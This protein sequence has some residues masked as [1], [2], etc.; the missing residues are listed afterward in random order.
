VPLH[1]VS[2]IP[3]H[4]QQRVAAC[5]TGTTNLDTV[6]F[7]TVYLPDT[8]DSMGS[9]RLVHTI[10]RVIDAMVDIDDIM[11]PGFYV[12]VDEQGS[13]NSPL[14]CGYHSFPLTL[15]RLNLTL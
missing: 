6:A 13:S 14:V 2:V 12:S 8:G 5:D 4:V 10:L 7:V 1:I 15:S 11:P 9:F 3:G